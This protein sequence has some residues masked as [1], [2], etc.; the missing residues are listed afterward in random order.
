[1]PSVRRYSQAQ[2]KELLLTLLILVPTNVNGFFQ[3]RK[4]P[5]S[6]DDYPVGNNEIY[7]GKPAAVIL[8]LRR[9]RRY[10]TTLRE[11]AKKGP[12]FAG[13]YTMVTWGSGLGTYSLAVVDAKSGKVY[14]PPFREVGNTSYGFT[15]EINP[16]WRVDSKLF[17][18]MGRLEWEGE[19]G[20][21]LYAFIH[22]RFRLVYHTDV[23]SW[24]QMC[25]ATTTP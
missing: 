12:N 2:M 20:V 4:K 21:Y 3:T 19:D 9:A 11:A 10:R 22:N 13:H 8:A 6:S 23:T 17:A 24:N 5:P 18:V 25:G 15:K 14:F 7:R 1:M 16:A